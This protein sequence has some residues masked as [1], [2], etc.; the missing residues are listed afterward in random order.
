MSL[1]QVTSGCLLVSVSPCVCLHALIYALGH[2]SAE[3]DASTAD[4]PEWSVCLGV[5]VQ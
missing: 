3:V 1:D 4:I 2:L 5:M